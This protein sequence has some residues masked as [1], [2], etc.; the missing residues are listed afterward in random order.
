MAKNKDEAKGDVPPW[1]AD[2][3]EAKSVQAP[4]VKPTPEGAEQRGRIAEQ[5]AAAVDHLPE[6]DD[7]DEKIRRLEAHIK[8]LLAGRPSRPEASRDHAPGVYRVSL[9]GAKCRRPQVTVEPHE[10]RAK[11]EHAGFA[12]AAYDG[13]ELFLASGDGNIQAAAWGRYAT[14]HGL[15]PGD[16]RGFRVRVEAGPTL[17][18][19]DIPANSPYEAEH[20]FRRYSGIEK[21]D[22]AFRTELLPDGVPH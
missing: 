19:L 20:L 7:R 10:R 1:A 2:K 11:P 13:L 17:E 21:T 5:V 18:H 16:R 22:Q 8:E 12:A 3:P 6:P 15:R 14:K 9:G 4:A